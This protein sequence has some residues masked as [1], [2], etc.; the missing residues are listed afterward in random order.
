MDI[1]FNF[2]TKNCNFYE[3]NHLFFVYFTD[4]ILVKRYLHSVHGDLE[5]AK[6][7]IEHSFQMRNNHPNIFFKR[8]P[9]S[10]ESKN[11]IDLA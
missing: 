3:I 8:D 10:K 5:K 4:E 2:P 9:L 11:I 7:L 6:K 1:S